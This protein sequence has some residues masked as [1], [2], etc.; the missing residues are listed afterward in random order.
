[1]IKQNHRLFLTG[2]MLGDMMLTAVAFGLAFYVRFYSGIFPVYFIPTL[3]DSMMLLAIAAPLAL[4]FFTFFGAYDTRRTESVYSDLPVI[5]DTSI[6]VLL[7]IS[8]FMFLYRDIRFSRLTVV[9]FGLLFVLLF[10]G[11]RMTL[12]LLLKYMR[13]IGF[14]TKRLLIVGSGELAE[15]VMQAVHNNPSYGYAIAGIL[16]DH[17]TNG[18]YRKSFGVDVIGRTKELV[19]VVESEAIDKVIIALPTSKMRKISRLVAQCERAGIEAEI[20]PD[21][22]RF[23]SAPTAVSSLDGL[24]LLSVNLLPVRGM[25][26]AVLK[27]TLDV[28]LA[29]LLLAMLTPLLAIVA[30]AI[31]LSS[32]GPVLFVQDRIGTNGRPFRMYKFRT[33]LTNAEAVLQRRLAEDDR[34]RRE[35]EVD[36]K[37]K[38][39]PRV[40]SIGSFLRRT[41]LDE[42]PQLFNVLHGTMSL[43]GPRPLPDYHQEILP[44]QVNLIRRRVL[45]GMTGL[46]QVSGRSDAGS[47]GM[48]LWDL[49]YVKNW[50]LWL[51]MMI[52]LRTVPAVFRGTGAL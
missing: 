51:D 3:E 10:A 4:I 25:A 8:A 39:D 48:A 16:D 50:S 32:P 29:S 33:M 41:S 5:F 28:V 43:V 52:L 47:E 18:F 21:V 37:L 38:H 30:V 40:T 9:L 36:F 19:P 22:Y 13:S 20:V 2:L 24:P 34:L 17:V 45:P 35:W 27:R 1:M 26:Y 7:A 46:W 6:A 44:Q 11:E 49:Y 23:L 15:R 12:R 42:L 14:N 31:R